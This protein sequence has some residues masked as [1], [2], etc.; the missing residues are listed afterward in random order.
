MT[1]FLY[2]I[3]VVR[4]ATFQIGLFFGPL[5]N[6]L[7]IKYNKDS[8][9]CHIIIITYTISVL[10]MASNYPNS[11]TCTVLFVCFLYSIV[12]VI[13]NVCLSLHALHTHIAH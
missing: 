9:K 6:I 4:Y 13:H 2:L 11:V 1:F 7:P 10:R 8:S 5:I 12:N 3:V